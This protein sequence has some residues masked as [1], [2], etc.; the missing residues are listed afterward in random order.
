MSFHIW[1]SLKP[2]I[3]YPDLFGWKLCLCPHFEKKTWTLG[4]TCMAGIK[5]GRGRRNLGV[6]GVRGR[7]ERNACKETIVFS[8]FHAQILS[9]KI[10]IGQN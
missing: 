9:M 7:K 1:T 8:M 3:L 10:V 6:Q 5:R 4:I 2:H